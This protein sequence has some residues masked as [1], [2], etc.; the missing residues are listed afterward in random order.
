MTRNEALLKIV[1]KVGSSKELAY[2]LKISPHYLYNLTSSGRNIPVKYIK[3][4]VDISKGEVK[5]K[6]LRPD[7]FGDFE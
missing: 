6:D 7:I 3:K 4:L 5:A 2:L 1:K